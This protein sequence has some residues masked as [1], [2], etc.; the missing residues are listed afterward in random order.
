MY[1][2]ERVFTKVFN[3]GG[4]TTLVGTPHLDVNL[5]KDANS[6]QEKHSYTMNSSFVL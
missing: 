3:E 1:T 2:T 6:W 5:Q 4:Q